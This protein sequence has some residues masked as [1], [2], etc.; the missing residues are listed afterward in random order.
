MSTP[1]FSAF[2]EAMRSDALAMFRQLSSEDQAAWAK[3]EAAQAA[4]LQSISAA[5]ATVNHKLGHRLKQPSS[6]VD[7]QSV[8]AQLSSI[9]ADC[10]PGN[11]LDLING[12]RQF[13][14]LPNL[15]ASNRVQYY[16]MVKQAIDVANGK[17]H[18]KVDL[19]AQRSAFDALPSDAGAKY[20]SVTKAANS[21]LIRT[22]SPQKSR[23]E[24]AYGV[25]QHC[26]RQIEG[27][28]SSMTD[29]SSIYAS[30]KD[31][32]TSILNKEGRD[33]AER[34]L[35]SRFSNEIASNAASAASASK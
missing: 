16:H 13:E 35:K 34:F 17:P 10:P 28:G 26:R 31:E 30:I 1:G 7:K 3:L 12:I 23:K 27:P 14:V 4:P 5:S 6:F 8:L 11:L 24:T 33:A 32:L 19:Q 22:P 2:F 9:T 25:Y 21:N 20:E 29:K 18:Q 15:G